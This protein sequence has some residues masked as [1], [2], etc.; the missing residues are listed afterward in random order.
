MHE[1]IVITLQ[2]GLHNAY[3][4]LIPLNRTLLSFAYINQIWEV[5]LLRKAGRIKDT[6]RHTWCVFERFENMYNNIYEA[7]VRSKVARKLDHLQ[8]YNEDGDVVRNEN[9]AYGL[10][11][12]Y[13]ITH[14]HYILSVDETGKNTNMRSDGKVGGKRFIV[15]KN[16][17]TNTGCLGSS[18]D[19][20]FTVLCFTAAT[21]EAVMCAIILKSEQDIS[22]IHFSW[23]FGIDIRK[24]VR[25]GKNEAET[26]ELNCGE[27]L[28]MEGGPECRF[29]GVTI[30]CF[31]GASPKA[32]ITSEMLAKMLECLDDLELFDRSDGRKPFLLCDG[33]HSRLELPFLNYIN[34][35]A[36]EWTVCIGVPYGTHLWQVHDSEELNGTFSSALTKAKREYFKKNC[37]TKEIHTIRYC[38]INQ[39]GLAEEFWS[40]TVCQ[41]SNL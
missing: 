8:Y 18:T 20:H 24:N 25:T 12:R 7:M 30:P 27:G 31:I 38:T 23:R 13:E 19:L 6:Q 40:E 32:S 11:T 29:N 14:P 36:H 9:E 10:P 22:K 33:H 35:K 16:A 28:A 39:H 2:A 4:R 26:F 1:S 15:P 37:H 3:L 34:D 21:G 5:P 41:K 17:V